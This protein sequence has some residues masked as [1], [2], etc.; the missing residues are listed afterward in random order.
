MALRDISP[1]LQQAFTDNVS[2]TFAH[3]I[4]FERPA[5]VS[6]YLG[7]GNTDAKNYTY[8][9]DAPYD[10]VFNDGTGNGPQVYRANK[11]LSVGTT[12]ETIKAK[13]SNI[14]VKLDSTTIDSKAL[15]PFITASS[16]TIGSS[17]SLTATNANFV[18][19]GFREG[20]KVTF[21]SGNTSHNNLS[22]IIKTFTNE[23]SGF[24]Y[25]AVDT[26]PQITSQYLTSIDLV[27]EELTALTS[28]KGTTEYSNYI[29][30]EVHIHKVF[31]ATE[32]TS[33]NGTNYNAGEIIG[34]LGS[35]TSPE[36]GLLLFRGLI[37]NAS[38]TE[39][40]TRSSITW[41]AASHWADFNRIQGRR[42]EDNSHRAINSDGIPDREASIREAYADDLGFAH[43]TT[44]V[45][46]TAVYNRRETKVEVDYDSGFL[47]FGSSV[48]TKE[49]EY[50]VPTELDLKFNLQAK[51]LPVVYGV[52]RVDTIPTFVDTRNHDSTE[53]HMCYAIA[54]GT[55]T[56]L[57]DLHLDGNSSICSDE[58]D[59]DVRGTVVAASDSD[60]KVD[61]ICRGHQNRG[62]TLAGYDAVAGAP[63]I[64]TTASLNEDAFLRAAAGIGVTPTVE[65]YAIPAKTTLN[66]AIGDTGLLHEETHTFDSPIDAHLTFHQGSPYQKANNTL[67]TIAQTSAT[68]AGGVLKN[69]KVQTDYY[70]K[71]E[72]YYGPNHRLLDTA[73]IHAEYK[74]SEGETELPKFKT[75]VR[76][77]A[78]ECYNYDNS[79]A[80]DIRGGLISAD[81]TN[82]QLGTIVQLKKTS[83]DDTLIEGNFT[84]VDKWFFY[85]TDGVKQYRFKLKDSNGNYPDFAASSNWYMSNGSHRW[86]QAT[87]DEKSVSNGAVPGHLYSAILSRGNKTLTLSSPSAPTEAA[88]TLPNVSVK[89]KSNVSVGYLAA[90]FSIPAGS[91]DTS[92]KILSNIGTTTWSSAITALLIGNGI[93]LPASASGSNDKYNGLT[94]VFTRTLTDGTTYVQ[95]RKIIDYHG[96]QRVAIV[97]APWDSKYIPGWD[98]SNAETGGVDT[99]DVLIGVDERPSTNPAMQLLDYLKSERYGKGLKDSDIDLPS[100]LE[101]AA[102]CDTQSD[103]SVVVE[104]SNLSSLAVGATYSHG[105]AGNDQTY[106]RGTVSNIFTPSGQTGTSYTQVTFTDVIGKLASK[107]NKYTFWVQGQKIWNPADG[108]LKS[109]QAGQQSQ[110][111]GSDENTLSLSKFSGTGP[112][113]LALD[114]TVFKAGNNNPV[115]KGYSTNFNTFI[116]SGY[117]LYDA[118]D[119]KYWKYIGW[120]EPTQR[121]ATR[122]QMN[123]SVNT[124]QPLFANVNKMLDQ[125]NGILR[126]SL[127]KYQLGLVGKKGTVSTLEKISQG[128]IIG[129]IKV[130]DNGSKKTYN[131]A[132]LSFPDPQNRFENRDISFFNSKFLKEDKGIPKNLSYQCRGIT[133]Y[134]NARFN[135]VQ[136]LK[137]SRFGTTINFKLGPRAYALLPGEVI[138]LTYPRFGWEEKEFRIT[139]INF[140]NDCLASITANEHSD[141]SYVIEST[142]E[143]LDTQFE[144]GGLPI[145]PIPD[146][147]SNLATSAPSAGGI[148]L[149]W[150]NSAS[151]GPTT[152]TTQIWKSASNR[153]SVTQAITSNSADNTNTDYTDV[154][155]SSNTHIAVGQL[156]RYRNS[157]ENVTVQNVSGNTITLD[158]DV[159]IL[160]GTELT[161]FTATIA[162]EV[163]DQV[164]YI[165]PILSS[166]ASVTRYYWLRYIIS[167]QE[168]GTGSVA[169]TQRKSPF[170]PVSSTAGVSGTSQ[171]SAAPRSVKL[172]AGGS[173]QSGNVITYDVNS[174]NP[175]PSAITFTATVQN[176]AGTV[177]YAWFIADPG[178][179]FSSIGTNSYQHAYTLPTALSG[180]PKLIK[181]VITDTVGSTD[182]T[183]EDIIE[184]YGTRIVANGVDGTDGAD[185]A[186]LVDRFL[187]SRKGVAADIT[188][189][190]LNNAVKLLDASQSDQECGMVLPAKTVVAGQKWNVSF[191]Y[192]ADSNTS[193]G[194]Y[195]R[196]HSDTSVL[197]GGNTAIASGF[198]HVTGVKNVSNDGS[199]NGVPGWKNG[200][201]LDDSAVTTSWQVRTFVYTV[202]ADAVVAGL[203][204]FKYS[205]MAT[206]NALYIKDVEFSLVG[207]DGAAGD[208]AFYVVSRL[209]SFTFSADS[210]GTINS[211]TGFQ[212][213]YT[214]YEGTQIF[215]FDSSAPY[216][217]N[218]Y[219]YGTFTSSETN[220]TADIIITTAAD[221]TIG[222]NS[223]SPFY[224]SSTILDAHFDQQIIN[225]NGNAVIAT[226]RTS[227][228]K[229]KAASA[230]SPAKTV[231]LRASKQLIEYA[232]D[233]TGGSGTIILTAE[234]QNFTNAY[235]KFTGNGITDENDWIDGSSANGDT[236]NFSVP[237]SYS[238]TP[239]VITVS[240][241][242][243]G[244]TGD[245]IATDTVTIASIKPGGAGDAGQSQKTVF[246]FKLN[247]TNLGFSSGGAS[248]QTFASPT[249][250]L[251]SGWSLTQPALSSDNDKVY[252]AQ[253]TFTSDGASPQEAS[254]STPVIVAQREDGTNG[255]GTAGQGSKTVFLFKRNDPTFASTTAGSFASP[256]NSTEAGWTLAQPA[257]SS[258]N[259]KVYM[260]QRTFTSDG[261]SPQDSSWTSPV[262]VAQRED[263]AAGTNGEDAITVILSNETHGIPASNAGTVPAGGFAGSGTTIRVFEGVT[264]LNS[265]S[266]T[267]GNSEFKVTASHTNMSAPSISVSGNPA[268]VAD[269][270]AMT[271]D[272]GSATY[273]I[274]GKRGDGTALPS[275]VKTQTFTK[276]KA[277]ADSTAVGVRG[278]SVFTF[279]EQ[280]T[281]QINNT[282]A[283]SWAGTLNNTSAQA[284]A[285]AVIAAASDGKIRPNDRIT[286]TDNSANLAGT[287]IYDASSATAT[288][289]SVT[290]NDFSPL[291]V[292]TF[293]GSVIVDGTLSAAKIQANSVT[294]TSFKVGSDIIVGTSDTAGAIH[295]HGKTSATSATNGFYLGSNS[296]GATVFAIGGGGSN[297]GGTTMTED[298]IRVRDD[299]GSIRVKIGD[300]SSL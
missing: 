161:F 237:T 68:T 128:D 253:R 37:S 7:V 177:G 143:S 97:N 274:T 297:S 52:Q 77:K 25:I 236:F 241:K 300:L 30:R 194:L 193:D 96:V 121:H 245:V 87:Y 54:E 172:T 27:S 292:E 242:E 206:S 110:F 49:V 12:N 41:T 218:S 208:D 162:A 150:T 109:A 13:A 118:D 258:D 9:T 117:S 19:L 43:A 207:E 119:I 125:F 142:Q 108:A 166:D 71:K 48:D 220:N 66:T 247:D 8:I 293:S 58:S 204:I 295:S 22:L 182:Y 122:H 105:V 14:T 217:S 184:I 89:L 280:D 59:F 195:A 113:T 299:S 136:K 6:Q 84:I 230:G 158:Q 90:N 129:D 98:L 266:G 223:S 192:K 116:G 221:G 222:I 235:F 28:V 168:A 36:G 74:I 271:A 151:F 286:V 101:T 188:F 263:G 157:P 127:G 196:I 282:Y 137:E 228:T 141:D 3:L 88:L 146:A 57:Y 270:T 147:P 268:V 288:S 46:L 264:E 201:V 154:V 255:V 40:P 257:L 42:T 79:Y 202:P 284:V 290:A 115:V 198:Y 173:G 81:H 51:Y 23:G 219:R 140:T 5:K 165:D 250:N 256:T 86:Y 254:W 104:T 214:V 53:V 144:P 107:W 83:N 38:L 63:Q 80:K 260:V 123:Q 138:Q 75:V 76:G 272:T 94:L 251:E 170:H 205:S 296:S 227:L 134:F 156:V 69:F 159:E 224:N 287:R 181:V 93:R 70:D 226:L 24:T 56:G 126:Y 152:H 240:V 298:G 44:G 283:T 135:I 131:S 199:T 279:E 191:A 2:F 174:A 18:E 281:A 180:L 262:I 111:T 248:G 130:T 85:D 171:P 232:A 175:N 160:S 189:S 289:S 15:S 11:V 34:G 155:V 103:V 231:S 213:T 82:F 31:I 261:N 32:L 120:D 95:R 285:A 244:N 1:N 249:N 55:I 190:T 275:I 163:K 106:F 238:A 259:D 153:R 29:N 124:S 67:V 91:Y 4:K 246:V 229:T 99:V 167:T 178:G 145:K 10:V 45:N 50:D 139:S 73:Y 211:L 21:K 149:T 132:N 267:P 78:I 197:S 209:P 239:Y 39:G 265:V 210:S 100:F 187:G 269:F 114:V 26:I 64:F 291:V 164:E 294:A 200:S 72:A 216:A 179:S 47:G 278:S 233:G 20:D 243:S 212:N 252:M 62:D 185:S 273:T 133:N 33:I 102:A 176:N 17:G 277:G 183:A 234:S 65:T 169:I 60:G 203:Q 215:T 112:G 92:S 225:N 61:F 35:N 16:T 186:Q 148:G 276:N